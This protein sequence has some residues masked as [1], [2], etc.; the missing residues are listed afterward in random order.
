LICHN[1]IPTT[2][3]RLNPKADNPEGKVFIVQWNSPSEEAQ[4]LAQYVQHL[5]ADQGYRPDEILVLSP[6][7]LL[8]YEIRDA[9][10]DIS[11]PT[12]SFFHEE[13]LEADEA[14]EAFTLLTLL[15][16]L[17]DRVS[18]RFW[19][20]RGSPSW[21]TGEYGRLRTHCES[22]GMSPIAALAK[23]LMGGLTIDR[24]GRIQERFRALITQLSELKKLTERADLVDHLFPD[25]KDWARPMRE[26]CLS[27]LDRISTPTELLEE[28]RIQITQPEMPLAGEFVRVM[29]LYKSKGLTS[30]VAIIA[31]C[32]EG[33]IPTTDSEHTSDEALANLREQRRLFYVS[34]TRCRE[35]LVLSSFLALPSELAYRIGARIK[36]EYG[37][38]RTAASRFFSELGPTRPSGIRGIDWVSQ[39]FS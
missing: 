25:E 19:L 27:S 24:T 36:N 13:S 29:S 8:G 38:G 26:V 28:L 12:H 33:L 7:R 4:G 15:T 22:S 31:G 2:A 23:L 17:E 32:V 34:M 5:I 9:L 21:N 11:V 3:V 14:Q 37:I 20:G 18:L 35:I 16:D 30:R 1:H 39:G 6:R 10:R